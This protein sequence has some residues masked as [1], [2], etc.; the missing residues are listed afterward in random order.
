MSAE[1]MEKGAPKSPPSKHQSKKA[2]VV[3]TLEINHR[4][5]AIR[6]VCIQEKQQ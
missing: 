3:R 6:G 4:L 1:T 5:V 2:Q